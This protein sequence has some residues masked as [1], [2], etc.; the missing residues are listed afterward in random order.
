LLLISEIGDIRRFP[1]SEKLCSYSGLVPSVRQSGGSTIHGGITWEGS[2]WMRLTMVEAS[3]VHLRYDTPV[4][5]FCHRVAE[6]RGAKTA[7][8]AAARKLLMVC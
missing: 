5:R 4:T 2:K 7:R 8:V 6:R 1:D 3:L